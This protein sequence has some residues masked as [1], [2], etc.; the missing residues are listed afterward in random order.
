MTQVLSN[1]L[2]PEQVDV[3]VKRANGLFIWAFTAQK[4][5]SDA[6]DPTGC[7]EELVRKDSSLNSLYDGI[8]ES[9]LESAGKESKFIKQVLQSICV[10]R[11]PLTTEMMDEF[12][13][14]RSGIAQRVVARFSSVLSDGSDG[15]AV[16]VLHPTFLEFIQD[17]TERLP[18]VRIEE[19]EELLALACLKALSTGLKYNICEINQPSTYRRGWDSEDEDYEDEEFANTNSE[20]E[21]FANANSEDEEFANTDFEDEEFANA[22]SEDKIDDLHEWLDNFNPRDSKPQKTEADLEQ[23]LHQST[24]PALG[25]AAIHGLSHVA[26]S[27]TSEIVI[28]ALRAFFE[29]N[30]LN[31]IELMGFYYEIRSVMSSVHN[32]KTRVEAEMSSNQLLVSVFPMMGPCA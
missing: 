17:S 16:H 27:I 2:T 30:L 10:A 25:Y 32:I 20:D 29:S 4:L 7:F 19:A 12:L 21:E 9:A 28:L 6:L 15:E 8:L 26:S 11:E 23:Q 13:G 1:H 18:I 22:N 3:L 5:I 31:W 24:T 14:F